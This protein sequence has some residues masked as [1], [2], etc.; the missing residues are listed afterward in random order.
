MSHRPRRR[1][2]AGRRRAT[3]EPVAGRIV[4]LG[5]GGDGLLQAGGGETAADRFFVP[6]TVP[7]D[8]IRAKPLPPAGEGPPPAALDAVLA[9]GPQRVPPP[10]P[11][12][13]QPGREGCGGCRMQMLDW[14]AYL[15]W[16]AGLA[17]SALEQHGIDPALV[18]A[19]MVA[20]QRSRRRAGFAVLRRAGGVV[21]G[22]RGWR[23]HRV[24]DLSD[25]CLVCAAPL[26]AL[27]PHLRGL[28]AELLRPGREMAAHVTATETG[29]D[30]VLRGPEPAAIDAWP[31]L[32]AFAEAADLARLSVAMPGHEDPEPV[33]LRRQPLLHFG[34][35]PVV[36]PASGFLQAVPEIEA[37]MQAE[38]AA[39][40]A[41]A[42]R[43]L[44]L[45]AGC[46][47]LSLPLIDSALIH[48]V[49]SDKA[50]L[51]AMQSG[52]NAA[53]RGGRVTVQQRDLTGF[54]LVGP[55]LTGFDAAILDPP[56]QGAAAQ[57]GALAAGGHRIRR[58]AAVSCNPASLAR[59]LARL[60]GGGWQVTA[61]RLYDQFLWTP[62]LELV[63]LLQRDT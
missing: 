63:A 12:F 39:W 41:G 42:G 20:P 37:A 48:A 23:S 62:H 31:R 6:G 32:T 15:D 30:V 27:L 11:H 26:P 3:A 52:A 33:L 4:A 50:A 28:G 2:S 43:V 17:R 45:Y 21:A 60:Q 25:A 61:V 40:L 34:P 36:P 19:P 35:V 58:I 38:T 18:E 16:K 1:A 8:E 54:P 59:D 46:G 10:C 51:Q 13:P 22:F 56:R 7:G 44:D 5:R 14:S 9:P 53:G 55:E 29:L 49:D 47:T 57:A 24:E